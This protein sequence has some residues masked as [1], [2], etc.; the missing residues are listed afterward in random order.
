MTLVN[1][2]KGSD[3]QPENGRTVSKRGAVAAGKNK[4]KARAIKESE[5][6]SGCPGRRRRMFRCGCL[7]E[8]QAEIVPGENKKE[9]NEEES[10]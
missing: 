7:G 9:Q 10:R 4:A 5:S 8:E 6:E 2:K 1:C 3:R